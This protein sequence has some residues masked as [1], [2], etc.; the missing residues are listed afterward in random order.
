MLRY[1]GSRYYAKNN[2]VPDFRKQ[3]VWVTIK[4]K[5]VAQCDPLWA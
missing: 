5:D 4:C 1:V 3:G 2:E